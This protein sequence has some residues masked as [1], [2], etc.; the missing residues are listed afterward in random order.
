MIYLDANATVAV[1]PEAREA[2]LSALDGSLAN[3]SSI[4]MPGSESR[5][6]LERARDAVCDLLPG[7]LPEGVVFTSG[8]TESNN[9]ILRGIPGATMVTTAVEHPSVLRPVEASGTGVIVPVGRNGIASPEHIAEAAIAD[10]R[11]VIVSV[12]WANSETGVIQP[13]HEIVKAVRSSRQDAFIHVDAAQAIGRI[14][15][16]IADIDAI[17][18]SGHKIHA[19]GGTG[20]LALADPDDDRLV[21]LLLGGGQ[22]RGRRSGTQNVAGIAGLGAALLQRAIILQQAMHALADLRT[23]FEMRVLSGLQDAVVNGVDAPRVPNTTNIRFPGID[24][25]SLVASLD[26][27]GVACS[28]GSAC[29]SARPVPSHVLTAMGLSETE[30]YSSVRFSF[31]I[32]NTV[33]E[34]TRAADIVIDTVRNKL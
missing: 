27:K 34:A 3:P 17:T 4:H 20:V 6:V 2:V 33:E 13:I 29:S 30:A 15:L 22:E 12:Q 11:P 31:S 9:M 23:G 18:F 10:I 24:A 16:D 14:P 5:H 26:Q 7:F 19:P 21:P 28:V 1:I 32:L 8:G 25:M